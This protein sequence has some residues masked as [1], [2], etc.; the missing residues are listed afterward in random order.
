MSG[1][2]QL[3][4]SEKAITTQALFSLFSLLLTSTQNQSNAV[5][6]VQSDIIRKTTHNIFQGTHMRQTAADGAAARGL[7]LTVYSHVHG[8]EAALSAS[9]L[10][11]FHFATTTCFVLL[12]TVSAGVSTCS[13]V[14]CFS[15]CMSSCVCLLF[16]FSF[17]PF[18]GV[19]G[20]VSQFDAVKLMHSSP[21]VPGGGGA[22]LLRPFHPL[23]FLLLLSSNHPVLYSCVAVSNCGRS[24]CPDAPPTPPLSPN[25]S[26]FLQNK[27]CPIGSHRSNLTSF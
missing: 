26:P 24:A 17:N 5:S 4:I 12:H 11:D 18:A 19:C 13:R 8:V 2:V 14:V 10:Y 22:A 16:L 15:C 7:Y 20:D 27:N 6:G 3:Y 23:L 1:S 21:V 25:H 9:P